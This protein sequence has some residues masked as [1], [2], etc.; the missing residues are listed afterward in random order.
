[1]LGDH[2]N[3]KTSFETHINKLKKDN[4]EVEKKC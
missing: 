4:E 2:K 1:M 3:R